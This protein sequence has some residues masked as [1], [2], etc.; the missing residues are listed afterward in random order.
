MWDAQITPNRLQ[1]SEVCL[2]KSHTWGWAAMPT[3]PLMLEPGDGTGQSVAPAVCEVFLGN[4]K[5][6]HNVPSLFSGKCEACGTILEHMLQDQA[7]SV[8]DAHATESIP[9]GIQQTR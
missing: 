4:S 7:S 5:L 1:Y 6:D 9:R 2:S 8:A 3:G